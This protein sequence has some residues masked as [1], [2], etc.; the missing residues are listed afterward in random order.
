MRASSQVVA[1]VLCL[2]SFAWAGTT[3]IGTASSWGGMRV[4]G[5]QVTSNATLF[6]GTIVETSQKSA[7][8]RIDKGL[9]IVLAPDSQGA[10]YRDHFVLLKGASEIDASRPFALEANGLSV[11]SNQPNSKGLVLLSGT[12]HV[13]VNTLIGSFN[14]TS[15]TGISLAK[16]G[17][18]KS[19]T[20]AKSAEGTGAGSGAAKGG[21]GGWWASYGDWVYVGI[22]AGGIGV[23]EAEIHSYYNTS[24]PASR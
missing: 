12:D 9:Q 17:P 4:D 18:G 13:A 20:F 24:P 23:A 22:I 21:N 14:V 2:S 6:D 10:L 8:L 5:N 11:T 19:M 3:A 15:E 16:L 7:T 1:T